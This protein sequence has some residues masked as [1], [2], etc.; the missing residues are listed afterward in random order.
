MSLS[1]MK[2]LRTR[3][4]NLLG[5]E[6]D[7]ADALLKRYVPDDE[8]KGTLWKVNAGSEEEKGG[9]EEEEETRTS[10]MIAE[11]SECLGE[12]SAFERQL[13]ERKEEC[14]PGIT[15]QLQS[16]FELQTQMQTQ[17]KLLLEA[18]Q[19]ANLSPHHTSQHSPSSNSANV[20]LPKLEITSFNGDILKWIEF[21]DSFASAVHYNTSLSPIDKF[22]YL[23][24]KL[25]G[26]ALNSLSGLTLSNENYEIA[27]TILKER[28]GDEQ[29]VINTHY[30]SLMDLSPSP[31]QLTR[32]RSLHDALERHLRSLEA[33]GQ[34]VNQEI[35]I[36]M[37]TSKLPKEVLLQLEM[38][39]G[40][41]SRWT[42]MKLRKLFE[43][44]IT[45]RE[46]AERQ[47]TAA[48]TP[49]TYERKSTNVTHYGTKPYSRHLRTSTEA[50]VVGA[51]QE[52]RYKQ[53]PKKV[54]RFCNKAHWSDECQE[55]PTVEDRKEKIKGSCYICLK[56]G[57][58][59]RDCRVDKA[60]RHCHQRRNHHRSLCPL[61]FSTGKRESSRLI[62]EPTLDDGEPRQERALMAAGEVVLMQTATARIR[63]PNSPRDSK[64][65]R[66][67]LDT[68]S[69]RSYITE[70]LARQLNLKP[71]RIEEI[72]IVTFG[73]D[74]AKIVKTSLTKLQLKLRDGTFL[75]MT[76]NIVPKITGTIHRMPLSIE[77]C[78]NWGFLWR[79]IPLADDI[80]TKVETSTIELLIGNDYY[81]DLILPE[82]IKV[83]AGLH[84]LGSRLGW[85]LA[86]RTSGE[87]SN[88]S[89]PSML[90]LPMGN[91]Q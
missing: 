54:C 34:N 12:L 64:N 70:T 16:M 60:C 5:K 43:L 48:A 32:L 80:P 65:V 4:R 66:L 82:K 25:T 23:R 13:Q 39:K 50:L 29:T 21:W 76:V 87:A 53:A 41:D 11:I 71:D 63:K 91:T 9:F 77:T 7:K 44:Y 1:Y 17:T 84:L 35:F 27:V 57:H 36:S 69:H 74:K 88:S 73:S 14:Q 61:R 75:T 56:K 47:S 45:A 85:L 2:G 33:L 51:E 28:F 8:L 40:A 59:I 46:S 30:T 26:E 89:E 19:Q 52:S 42:V 79:G 58:M 10:V 15:K 90:I 67:L 55:Y 86:G 38:Q 3:Y 22:N 72:P 81:L 37:I 31:N 24:S 68:G 20:K 62:A 83:H 6:T 78:T 18:Q 49:G